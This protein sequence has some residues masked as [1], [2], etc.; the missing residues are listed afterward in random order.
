MDL[1]SRFAGAD[2]FWERH[3]NPTSGWSRLLATP[4]LLAAVYTRNR[5]LLGV[6]LAWTAV[7]PVAFPP[8]ERG[9]DPAWMT[10]VVDA[11]RAWL[12]GEVTPGGSERL[13]RA[14][15]VL[16]GYALYAAYRRRP[17]RASLAGLVSMGLKLAFVAVLARRHRAAT[18]EAGVSADPVG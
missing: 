5:K 4:L 15:G 6:A 3:A 9:T 1:R 7:N 16:F 18:S 12:R 14:G 11:E 10:R 17:S 8:V 13:N 2:A